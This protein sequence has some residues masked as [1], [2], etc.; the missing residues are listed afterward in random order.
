MM[1]KKQKSTKAEKASLANNTYSNQKNISNKMQ[2]KEIKYENKVKIIKKEELPKKFED[3]NFMDY[4]C[5]QDN[6]NTYNYMVNYNNNK[7]EFKIKKSM[8]NKNIIDS[9]KIRTKEPNKFGFNYPKPFISSSGLNENIKI[10]NFEFYS[11]IKYNFNSI[12]NPNIDFSILDYYLNSHS[13]MY[14][15]I[16]INN[17][18]NNTNF[19]NSNYFFIE[20]P[21][22][23]SNEEQYK[24]QNEIQLKLNHMERTTYLLKKQTTSKKLQIEITKNPTVG[25]KVIFPLIKSKINELIKNQ[26]ANYAV[27][28][29]ITTLD[30]Y[31]LEDFIFLISNDI[32]SICNN[33][34]STRV[35][36][37]L[38]S[39]LKTQTLKNKFVKMFNTNNIIN[40][41][42]HKNGNYVL[43]KLFS[44]LKEKEL[45]NFHETFLKFLDEIIM[46]KYGSCVIQNFLESCEVWFRELLISNMVNNIMKYIN[47][48][49][50]NYV[51]LYCLKYTNSFLNDKILDVCKLKLEFL[52]TEKH[53]YNIIE[54]SI[55]KS[56]DNTQQVISQI[57][58]DKVET[59]TQLLLSMYGNHVLQII[60]KISNQETKQKIMDV[61]K[62]NQKQLQ[63][64][65]SYGKFFLNLITKEN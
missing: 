29:I 45:S 13:S 28:T 52:C 38:I 50:A 58:T 61:I 59:I 27:Q 60:F 17:M 35:V 7:Q 34:F 65:L 42:R 23:I 49:F 1:K 25:S 8:K 19:L 41:L 64:N 48:P 4:S 10:P 54:A 16:N 20:N 36:Q 6:N 9:K 31:E 51:I 26:F 44:V 39:E 15:L 2:N 47:H 12:M 63:E 40:I 21:G 43:R 37:F 11:T 24:I 18:G 3:L 5:Y 46:N 57:I 14:P 55:L 32:Q 56:S 30:S 62:K 53:S 33:K 22:Q